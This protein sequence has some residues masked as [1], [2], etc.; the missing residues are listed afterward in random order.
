IV[1]AHARQPQ[2]A[3]SPRQA[4]ALDRIVLKHHQAVEQ[5]LRSRQLLDLGEPKMLVCNQSRLAVLHLLEQ[6]EQR[7]RRRQLDPQRQRVDEPPPHPL[8]PGNPSRPPATATP[9]TTSS[10]PLIRPSKRPHAT[11]MKVLSVRPCRRAC[12]LSAVLSR[13]LSAT[14][15]CSA[16]TAA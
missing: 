14:V 4:A 8:N 5:R 15:I 11:C 10:R 7:L 16:A 1:P 12:S 6:F 9:N 2:T 13:S 3:T